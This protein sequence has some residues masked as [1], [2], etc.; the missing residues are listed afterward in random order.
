MAMTQPL[1]ESKIP[2]KG[3]GIRDQRVTA[4]PTPVLD[5]TCPGAWERVGGV[6]L[7]ERIR[8]HLGK[9][10]IK[11]AFL[12]LGPDDE[13]PPGITQERA[14]PELKP[15]RVTG[16][17]P[18]ALLSL[19]DIKGPVLYLRACQLIDPRLIEHLASASRTTLLFLDKEERKNRVIRA[20]LM[21]AEA[22][23]AWASGD[24]ASLMERSRS[25]FPGD[26]DLYSPELRG[27]SAPFLKDVRS[28]ADAKRATSLLIR[29]QQKRVMDWPARFIDPPFENALTGL[30]CETRITPNMVTWAGAFVALV[31]IGLFWQGLFLAGALGMFAI[32]I[33]DGVD[34]KLA[35]TRLLFSRLGHY[36][37][38]V[39]YFCENGMYTALALGLGNRV[40][41]PL[42]GILAGLLIFSDTLDN[43]LYTLADRW[44]NKS[45]DLFSPFD[46][47]FRLI[48][49]RRNIYG[50][51]FLAGFFLGFPFVT[52]A[53]AA[54]WAC[55]TAL[56]HLIRLLGHGR[57]AG[58][59]RAAA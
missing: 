8:F 13:P 33:L 27:N 22:L 57:A 58:N 34:G 42:P 30:L 9:I 4:G 35:R 55:L 19:D 1:R 5:A 48:A 7:V 32:E 52:Y 46:A 59:I 16:D 36:E 17:M 54:L 23:R 14:G 3:A 26:I 10:G 6:P 56:V 53:I 25:L 28:R 44:Y 12:L 39:D 37:S 51:M 38:V 31:V 41:G 43:V 15:L 47:A 29:S 20:G 40:D 18:S 50:M 45:I 21:D 24:M 2:Q 49:G 11:E